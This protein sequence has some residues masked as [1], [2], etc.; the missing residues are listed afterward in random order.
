MCGN[1]RAYKKTHS[2]IHHTGG[3]AL[4]LRSN[5]PTQMKVKGNQP[6]RGSTGIATLSLTSVP[7]RGGCSTPRPGRFTT[8]K[9][10]RHPFHRR[11]GNPRDWSGSV[12]KI[13]R[14]RRDSIPGL[15]SPWPAAVQTTISRPIF[16]YYSIQNLTE[17][18]QKRWQKRGKQLLLFAA[19][20]RPALA[21]SVSI[22]WLEEELPF[23]VKSCSIKW[24]TAVLNTLRTGDA[25]RF[26][27]LHYNCARRMTQI[28]VFNT[29]LFSLHN[30]LNY[31]IHRS[32]LRMVLLKDF[33]ETW[34]HPELTFRHLASCI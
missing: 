13:S 9:E 20:T 25:R 23:T 30:R 22:R 28:C 15:S 29:R 8:G 26:A 12:R 27:F 32:C 7:V 2:N 10:T 3:N 21:P 34:P 18:A 11:L 16:I 6:Y 14:P 1:G 31:A 17:K 24:I 5:A 33:I 19:M 4:W